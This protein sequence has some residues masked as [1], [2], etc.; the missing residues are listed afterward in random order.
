VKKKIKT[1][2]GDK[3]NYAEPH[4]IENVKNIVKS[5][6]SSIEVNQKPSNSEKKKKNDY[7]TG[8]FIED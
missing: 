7:T 6:Y 1:K 4:K 3:S 5:S 8:F 2:N